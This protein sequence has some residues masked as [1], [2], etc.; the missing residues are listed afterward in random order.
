[1]TAPTDFISYSHKDEEWKD[2]LVTHLGVLQQ[3]GLLGVWDDRRIEVGADWY[4]EIEQAMQAASV[5]VLM[6]SANFLTSQFILGEEVPRLLQRRAEEG[7]RVFPV[8]VKP[9]AWKQVSWLSRLQVRPKDGKPLSGGTDY[10]VDVDLAAIAE[11]IAAG[12]KRSE[13]SDTAASSAAT[14]PGKET[15]TTP[16]P[17]G[18]L[19]QKLIAHFSDGELHDLCFDLGIDYESL[20]GGTRD[21]RARELISY[22]QRRERLGELISLCRARRPS[23]SWGS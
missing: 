20:G 2:R 6:V 7:V 11:E 21:A 19:R 8:I 18:E 23:V 10:Q 4:P 1:M 14:R 22:L 5:A 15:P 16:L 9:C 3:E 12:L 13:P 17:P